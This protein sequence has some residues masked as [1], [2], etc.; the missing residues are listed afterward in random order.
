MQLSY[1][2]VIVIDLD[3]SFNVHADYRETILYRQQYG[4]LR[5]QDTAS[6]STWRRSYQIV[7]VN[8]PQ[9]LSYFTH[10]VEIP[11]LYET[12]ANT[13][14]DLTGSL[15]I[16]EARRQF[17]VEIANILVKPHNMNVGIAL[18]FRTTHHRPWLTSKAECMSTDTT[19][20]N[21]TQLN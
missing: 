8:G 16:S 2:L 20:R 3:F 7:C 18:V 14:P 6:H 1:W 15:L 10:M 9:T 21:S 11:K 12:T 13:E 17:L 4:C 5:L 19:Q